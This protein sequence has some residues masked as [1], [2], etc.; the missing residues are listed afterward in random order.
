MCLLRTIPWPFVVSCRFVKNGHDAIR[1]VQISSRM[2]ATHGPPIHIGNPS[3]RGIKDVYHSELHPFLQ[4]APQEPDEIAMFWGCGVTPQMVAL[5]SKVPF[6][7]TRYAGH[8]FITDKLS[9]ELA[10]L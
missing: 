6:M 3:A 7:I 5:E 2:R 10:I 9:E 8:M 4:V 1:A